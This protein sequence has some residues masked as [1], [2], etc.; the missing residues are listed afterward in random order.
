MAPG[1][2]C[3]FMSAIKEIL[4]RFVLNHF[5]TARN[6]K[7]VDAAAVAATT[8]GSSAMLGG[9]SAEA[10]KTKEAKVQV[11]ECVRARDDL[12][13]A[14]EKLDLPP[15]FLDGARQTSVADMTLQQRACACDW[16]RRQLLSCL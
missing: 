16:G 3:G 14:I 2:A 4:R 13:A 9:S 5:P 15:H 11:D 6:V 10:P 7:V 1:Q 8:A 12:L